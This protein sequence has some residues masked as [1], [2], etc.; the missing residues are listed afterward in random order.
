VHS[1]EEATPRWE[2]YV[3]D[4]SLTLLEKAVVRL[5]ANL[6]RLALDLEDKQLLGHLVSPT[7]GVDLA[8]V[9]LSKAQV[10]K[11]TSLFV[12]KFRRDTAPDA[13]GEGAALEQG[14]SGVKVLTAATL[15]RVPPEIA[16]LRPEWG[17]FFNFD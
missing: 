1:L 16:T 11:C 14:G 12:G 9:Q 13:V 15:V 17:F 7:E 8:Q 4:V 6:G 5:F 3:N 2:E 10:A